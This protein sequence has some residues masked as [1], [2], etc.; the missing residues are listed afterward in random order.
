MASYK[1]I[2]Y[3]SFIAFFIIF[4]VHYLFKRSNYITNSTITTNALGNHITAANN[5]SS[6]STSPDISHSNYDSPLSHDNTTHN[7]DITSLNARDSLSSIS[8]C[9]LEQFYS[10]SPIHASTSNCHSD[11]LI[12]DVEYDQL[13]NFLISKEPNIVTPISRKQF[14]RN[15]FS[16]RDHNYHNTNIRFDPVDK[17]AQARLHGI[18]AS[19]D[20]NIRIKDVY[21][22][23]VKS[24]NLYPNTC[25]RSPYFDN[26]NP[27]GYFLNHGTPGTR[28]TRNDWNYNNEKIMNGGT[29]TN[30]IVGNELSSTNYLRTLTDFD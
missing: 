16:F 1:N 25:T 18:N 28:L 17:I 3:Y 11:H 7:N 12:D 19:N 2:I 26:V 20:N 6:P 15:F 30:N 8:G 22:N 13:T 10:S 21:D 4:V 9:D 29:I 5:Y 23:L 24:N 27:Q 14:H